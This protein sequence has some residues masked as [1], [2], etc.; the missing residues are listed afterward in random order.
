MLSKNEGDEFDPIFFG[1][2]TNNPVMID[3]YKADE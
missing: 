3:K 1:K 2:Y